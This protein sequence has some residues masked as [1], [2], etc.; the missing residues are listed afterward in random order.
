[1]GNT[2]ELTK[3]YLDK[4][5]EVF[6]QE[7]KKTLLTNTDFDWTGAHSVLIWKVSTA[8][9]NDYVRSANQ[10]NQESETVQISR[11]G[12]I[13]DLSAQTEELML[14]KDRSFIYNID[15]LDE[16][17]TA[18]Q[19]TAAETLSRQLREVVIPEVDT[20][21]Y[22]IMVNGAGTK[23]TG[24]D[25]SEKNIYSEILKGSEALDDAEVPDTERV[26]AVTPAVYTML[27]KAT[28]F[29][30]T[31]VGAELRQLGVVGI[32]DGMQVIKIP[33]SRL[34]EG[35]GFMI[36]H[37]SATVA[38]TKLEDYHIHQDTPLA[39]GSIVTGRICY[40]AFVLDNKKKGIY[41]HSLNKAAV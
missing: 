31:D 25:L 41:Y 18:Q 13:Q 38:P 9:M 36:A 24:V 22:G 29:D 37:P 35:F 7:S 15:K 11:F 2:I 32:L 19:V 21:T 33:A 16:D 20:Y 8:Q 27:K 28:E 12:S 1:M 5:D 3:K 10:D 6:K 30:N 26:L 40:D 4:T 34:P 17:E 14:K 39:S 23:E